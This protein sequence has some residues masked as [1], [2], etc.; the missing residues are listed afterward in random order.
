[1]KIKL[2]TKVALGSFVVAGVGVIIFAL[3]SYSQITQYFQENILRQISVDVENNAND[4]KASVQDITN[5]V[6][7][8]SKSENVK[9]VIRASQNKFDYDAVEN[10][11][12]KD[13]KERVEKTFITYMEQNRAYFQMRLIGVG[14]SGKEIVR[15]DNKEGTLKIVENGKLQ[16]KGSR[17]YF[18]DT[19]ALQEGKL[20]ISKID[21]NK[22]RGTIIFPIVPTIRVA[23]PIYDA[24]N[25]LFGIIIINAKADILFS[26]HKYKNLKGNSVYLANSDGYYLFHDNIEKTF[27][28]EFGKDYRL[29]ND[30]DTQQIF[31]KNK[32]YISSY[33][34]DNIAFYAKKIKV[35]DSFIVL[36]RSASDLFLKEQSSAYEQ[37]MFTYI[38][39][40][41]AMIA[42]FSMI[43]TRLLTSPIS[44]LSER[45]K[46]MAQSGDDSR[47]NFKDIKTNDEIGELAESMDSMV[48][49][50]LS[51]KE[52]LEK[53][54]VSLEEDV[55][56]R[57]KDQ[58]ILLSIFDKGDAV[59]FKWNNDK[60]WSISS[61]SHSVK[62]LLGYRDREFLSQDVVY[63][64]C[65]HE[66]DISR[67]TQEVE[68]A[69]SSHSYFLQHKPYRLLTKEK[70]IKWVNDYTII[71]R[72]EKSDKITHFIGYLTDITALVELNDELEKKVESGISKLRERDELLAQQ[73]KLASMGEMIGAIA[74]QWRQPLNEIGIAIQN[75]KYDYEDGLVD[76]EFLDDFIQKNKE[77]VK[78]MSTTIDDFRNFYRVDKTKELFDVREAINSTL[79]LQMAQLANHNISVS[80]SG[81]SFEVNGFKNEFLQVILNIINNAKDALLEN[82]IEDAKITILLEEKI[83]KIRDNAGGIPDE[84]LERIF[85]PYFTTKEQG[86]GTGMGL[87]M[88]KMIIEENM[89]AELSVANSAIGA[90]FRMDFHEKK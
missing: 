27:G 13:W 24:Q 6:L 39:I 47:I 58:E 11:K 51:S 1:M 33:T 37:K 3:L 23:T 64:E 48:T 88:S 79:S 63:A 20:F 40:V 72:D 74:H 5:D 59:L 86:K 42:I 66:E 81:E 69:I 71:V 46:L 75:L 32:E 15:V 56:Q 57:T 29:Q 50:I 9:G 87:Y 35:G 54:T 2:S 31:N 22:E 4:I 34:E 62:K 41:T 80:I 45:A 89:D 60:Q 78:F 52:E 85:E 25:R 76:K 49:T 43:L 73:S 21:L 61:V 26:L 68:D 28:F 7:M 38:L 70:K 16:S 10:L 14:E 77:I 30:F 82:E 12:L 18:K 53:L 36:A 17:Y 19:I 44:T 84:I 83:I 90:E 55:V 67:V 8:L 65:I